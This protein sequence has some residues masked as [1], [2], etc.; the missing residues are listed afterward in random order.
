MTIRKAASL[1]GI[2]ALLGC[3]GLLIPPV[4][5]AVADQ[6]TFL[7]DL[8]VDDQVTG[9]IL[10]VDG[11]SPKRVQAVS[12]VAPAHGHTLADPVELSDDTVGTEQLDDG[13]SS[14]AT[15]ECVIVSAAAGIGGGRE[16]DYGTCGGG[17]GGL[18]FG[19]R[20]NADITADSY[21]HPMSG[22]CG[23]AEAS[24]GMEV[25]V[26]GTAQNFVVY[27]EL[28]QGGGDTC[29]WYIQRA[30]QA[31]GGCD[32]TW[33]STTITVSFGVNHRYADTSNT[34]AFS[35][36]DCVRIFM[37]EAA[38]TCTGGWSWVFEIK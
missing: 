8:F 9:E 7:R 30:T 32:G 19:A 28:A 33:G 37:D 2:A 15:G 1:L 14:P 17:G 36:G 6:V 34:Q 38:G 26:A 24:I 23:G 31:S 13:A 11:S 12:H 3:A 35:V 16:L 27:S 5:T 18:V 22:F 29:D 25:M 20:S 21:C 4:R 10:Q